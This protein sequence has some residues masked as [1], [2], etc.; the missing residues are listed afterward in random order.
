MASALRIEDLSFRYDRGAVDA[1][2]VVRISRFE[3]GAGEMAL[4]RGR[5]GSGKTTLLSLI[6]GLIEPTLGRVEIAG[7]DVHGLRGAARDRFRGRH[8]GVVFQTF[9]LLHGFSALENVLAGM[10]FSDIPRR[11]HAD[12]ARTL[13]SQLGIERMDAPPEQLSVGQQQRVAVAR[14]VAARPTLVLA[15]EPTASLD[16]ENADAAIE[17]IKNACAEAG[18]AL[19]C[20]SHDPAASGHFERVEDLA[21]LAREAERV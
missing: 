13:L 1:P 16:P 14:A 12:R 4:L 9:N 21:I 8:L 18:A 2:P 10:M 15:D 11:E 5:S 17:L 19:L 20:V 6:A 3:L 7:Q